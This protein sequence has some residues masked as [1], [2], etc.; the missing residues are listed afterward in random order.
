MQGT[1]AGMLT[2]LATITILGGL[3]TAA[4]GAIGYQTGL[5]G[6]GWSSASAG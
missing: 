4:V 6:N 3:V 2:A 1:S 5:D